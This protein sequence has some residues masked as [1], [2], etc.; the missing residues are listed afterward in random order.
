MRTDRLATVAVV[1]PA[2]LLMLCLAGCA[3]PV[4]PGE[5]AGGGGTPTAGV[6]PTASVTPTAPAPAAPSVIGGFAHPTA[7]AAPDDGSDRLF[8]T[9]QAGVIRVVEHGSVL[10]APALDIR[11]RVGSQ[12]NEQGLLGL[13]F[14]PGFAKKGY[15]YIYFTD[16]S[17]TSQLY[18]L[19]VSAADP[20]VFD[21]S[22]MQSL[23]TVA[24]PFAN[25]N[26]GQLAFGPDGYL[27]FGL[28]DGGSGGD[29]GNR[30]QNLSVLLG[31]ILRI[32]TE[33]APDAPGY[34]IPPDNPF[35]GR[36]GA[37]P[38]IWA[39]GLRNPWRFS[40]DPPTG[41]MWIADVGQDRWEEIDH[42]AGGSPAGLNFGWSLY[43]GNELFKARSRVTAGYVWPV[44]TYSHRDG[45]SVTG[46]YVY[47]GAAYP[48]M[49]G[50]YVFGDYGSGKIWTTRWDGTKWN[51]RL[52]RSTSY[53]ISTFGLDGSGELWV[54]DYAAGKLHRVEDLTR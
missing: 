50:L 49:R 37:R 41:D 13:A 45:I 1:L 6:T 16:T 32:D 27:Y 8:V 5:P 2:W 14:P 28:G 7:M 42:V 46:G 44:F 48:A 20:N 23:L 26:G 54:A 53:N 12:G 29:P 15:A 35:V 9:D 30:A 40:F 21:P 4:P 3:A 11:G 47:R 17:G 25:H 33:S 31:K 51:T 10:K 43:E 36:S 22:T 39:Y 52:A 19:H 38:E 24:Q 18:R 34:G